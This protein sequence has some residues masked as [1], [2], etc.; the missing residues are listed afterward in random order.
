MTRRILLFWLLLVSFVFLEAREEDPADP[1]DS[2]PE[3]RV[4]PVSLLLEA[5]EAAG[6]GGALWNP[7]WPP[8]MPPDAFRLQGRGEALLLSAEVSLVPADSPAMAAYRFSRDK[9]GRV[10]EFPFL[11]GRELFQA[12]F[13]Y[14]GESLVE[15]VLLTGPGETDSLDLEVLEWE[16]SRPSLIRV[17]WGEDYSFIRIQ[18][19]PGGILEAWYDAEG[20]IFGAY[21]FTLA[22]QAG[23]DRIVSYRLR[24]KDGEESCDYDSRG[25][26]TGISGHL[27]N[28][29]VVY[30]LEDLPRYWDYRP[31]ASDQEDAGALAPGAYSLR[32]DVK[33]SLLHGLAGQAG[34]GA[35]SVDCRYEYTLDEA[36]NW[37]ERREIRMI[38]RLGLLLPSP[39]PI[40]RRVLEYGGEE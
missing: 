34:E 39:G 19:K 38:R 9:E 2:P 28:F 30:Y 3:S 29:S 36:G 5:A 6:D 4:F 11:F 23:G 22:P 17:L 8:E 10:G 16:D 37:I 27:G 14:N 33:T 18:R 13:S 24:G 31:A 26:V 25:F 21:D 35:D 1:P 32:W 7:G 15:S 12:E 40:I 20:Q